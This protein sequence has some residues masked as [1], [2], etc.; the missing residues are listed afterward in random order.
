VRVRSKRFKLALGVAGLRGLARIRPNLCKSLWW[1]LLIGSAQLS[2]PGLS[3][4][5]HKA[6]WTTLFPPRG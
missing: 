2:R 1:Q 3:P 5:E 4:L 6:A